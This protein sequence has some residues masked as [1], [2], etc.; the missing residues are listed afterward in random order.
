MRQLGKYFWIYCHETHTR[1][2]EL[3]PYLDNWLNSS[4]SQSTGY[5]PVE[6]L[7][8]NPKPDIFRKILKKAINQLPTEEALA[9]KILKAYARMKLRADKRNAR[10]KTVTTRWQPQLQETVPVRCQPVSDAAHGV[11]SKFKHLYEGSSDSPTDQPLYMWISG[12]QG[13]G[14]R[15]L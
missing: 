13:Q 5:S 15:N 4:V 1:W 2:P 12:P 3:V 6:L 9:N 7:N 8:G 14:Q 11:I 10:R